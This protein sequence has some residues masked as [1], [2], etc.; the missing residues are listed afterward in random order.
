MYDGRY[1]LSLFYDLSKI[2]PAA[3][4]AGGL[5]HAF[6]LRPYERIRL[7]KSARGTCGRGRRPY[8]YCHPISMGDNLHII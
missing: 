8:C 5:V 1:K 6:L 2:V 4:L 3:T 7:K